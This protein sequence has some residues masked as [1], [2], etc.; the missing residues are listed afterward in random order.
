MER[1]MEQKSPWRW[2]PAGLIG[3]MLVVLAVNGGMVY[4]ALHTFPGEAGEDG[5]DL[6]NGYGRVLEGAARQASL[7]WHVGASA[8]AGRHPALMLTARGGRR[9]DHPAVQA[10]AE[11]PLGPPET[12]ALTLRPEADGRLVADQALERGQWLLTVIVTQGADTLSTT[13]RLVI[14]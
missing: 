3:A 1:A 2:F 13:E 4:A 9:L 12:T 7:G 6:G 8:D 11:R 5:F 14:R 10:R